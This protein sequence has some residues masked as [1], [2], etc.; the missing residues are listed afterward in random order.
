MQDIHVFI[1]ACSSVAFLGGCGAVEPQPQLDASQAATGGTALPDGASP[2]SCAPDQDALF[3]P[4]P[5]GCEHDAG[6]TVICSPPY[7]CLHSHDNVFRCCAI[8]ADEESRVPARDRTGF[9]DVARTLQ[10]LDA[11]LARFSD[12]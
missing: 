10:F 8:S 6:C 12:Q 11:G 5:A 3:G 1:L 9:C 7:R 2:M 4:G